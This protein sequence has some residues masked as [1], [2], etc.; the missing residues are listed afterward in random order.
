MVRSPLLTGDCGMRILGL[1]IA[2]MAVTTQASGQ[3]ATLAHSTI[4]PQSPEPIPA[5]A[6]AA[7]IKRSAIISTKKDEF[8]TTGQYQARLSQIVDRE[9]PGSLISVAAIV[10]PYKMSYDADSG[11]L[12]VEVIRTDYS[13][14]RSNLAVTEIASESRVDGYYEAQNSYGA[15][16]E[17]ERRTESEVVIAWDG[18]TSSFSGTK[19]YLD[20]GSDAAR[21]LKQHA[22]LV[23]VG[24]LVAPFL[25]Q[26]YDL[27][28]PTLDSPIR[29]STTSY[30]LSIKSKCIYLRDAS[31]KPY[32]LTLAK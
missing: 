9:F 10:S 4:C 12:T 7:K 13:V 15:S 20:V 2:A 23:I 22:E 14:D 30:A 1:A 16:V 19:A 11:R 17:V 26:R 18:L 29:R 27:D 31:R 32:G 3:D 5:A 24:S 8:E 6:L 28:L 21:S 25:E